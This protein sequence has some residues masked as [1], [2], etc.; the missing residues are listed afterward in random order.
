[1][2]LVC[3]MASVIGLT[4]ESVFPD[5][6]QESTPRI[7]NGSMA[8]RVNKSLFAESG[9]TILWS[10]AGTINDAFGYKTNHYVP[11]V[12]EAEEMDVESICVGLSSL[13]QETNAQDRSEIES[14]KDVEHPVVTKVKLTREENNSEKKPV[15]QQSKLATFLVVQKQMEEE[16]STKSERG[17]PVME[18]AMV[19]IK[20]I[21]LFYEKVPLLTQEEK[22]CICLNVRTPERSYEFPRSNES[23]AKRAFIF[24]WFEKFHWLAYSKYLDGAFCL[25]CVLF[26]RATGHKIQKLDKLF[27]SPLTY[28][29]S[30]LS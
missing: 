9:V 20:D 1:M 4:I 7:F 14:S 10:R 22:Y 16:G 8:P 30:A 19:N 26:G 29:T 3:L 18:T 28:W 23:G 27:K 13:K 21:G 17:K 24:V 15:L 6:N 5:C 11:L 25:P 2:A 12:E